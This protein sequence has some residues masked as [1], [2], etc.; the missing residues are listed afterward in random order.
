M[1]TDTFKRIY[2][3]LKIVAGDAED[4]ASLAAFHYRDASLGPVSDIFA[5][6]ETNPRRKPFVP[7]VGVIVYRAPV[8]NLGIRNVAT[9]GFFSGLDR[10]SGLQLLN[11]HVRCISRVIID[12]R[13]RGLGLASRLVR[14]TLSRVDAAMVE[15]SAV[16]G[17]CH[18]FFRKAGMRQWAPAPSVKTERMMTA[19]ETVG[20][21][22]KHWI[23]SEAVHGMIETLDKDRRTFIEQQINAFLQKFPTQRNMEHSLGRTDFVLSKLGE[24]ANYYT[25]LN[26]DKPVPGLATT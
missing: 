10:A 11:E 23:D 6:V 22:R 9:S 5:M 26:P 15:A 12:P 25:W 16:M 19:L 17:H 21:D 18:P 4:Y 3:Y 13:Y 24:P 7:A 20:I 1:P 14:E 2:K 8:P